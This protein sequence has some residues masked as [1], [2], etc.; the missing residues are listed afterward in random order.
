M[1][2]SSSKQLWEYLQ[3]QQKPFV[4]DAYL[5]E[6]KI[7]L[8]KKQKRP[9][10][11]DLNKRRIEQTRKILKLLLLKFTRTSQNQPVSSCHKAQKHVPVSK[12]IEK[13]RQFGEIEWL[14]TGSSSVAVRESFRCN[15]KDSHFYE[16]H[17][18]HRPKTSQPLTHSSLKQK[19]HIKILSRKHYLNF[20]PFI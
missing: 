3:E 14:P 17:A 15:V 5:S 19:V 11:Y 8:N 7:M 10:S 13:P 6:R 12:T 20:I 1:A 18:S 2:S 9:R 4:L 16:N